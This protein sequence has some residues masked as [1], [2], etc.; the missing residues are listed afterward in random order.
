MNYV[1][2]KGVKIIDTSPSYKNSE[3]VIGLSKKKFKIISKIPKVPKNIKNDLKS[4]I[5]KNHKF[6]KNQKKIYGI[7]VQNAE[8]LLS[9]NSDIIFNTLLNLKAG[10]F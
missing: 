7:L 4:W 10:I 1:Y 8:I 6:K 2:Q 5:I 9:K 3:K